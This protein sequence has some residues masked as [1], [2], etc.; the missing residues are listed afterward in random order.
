[1]ALTKVPD[2]RNKIHGR[3]RFATAIVLIFIVK[4]TSEN[5]TSEYDLVCVQSR[6]AKCGFH[7]RIAN[8]KY[9]GHDMVRSN[10]GLLRGKVS[11]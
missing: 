5:R 8:F 4:Q 10:G 7:F 1:M 6:T 11:E 3:R 2:R 9:V